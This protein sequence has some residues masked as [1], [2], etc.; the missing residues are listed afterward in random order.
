MITSTQTSAQALANVKEIDENEFVMNATL[1]ICSSLDPDIAL[2]NLLLYLKDYIP[3]AG[4]HL[5]HIDAI[6]NGFRFPAWATINNTKRPKPFVKIPKHLRE[7]VYRFW[8]MKNRFEV[9]NY[10]DI[11]SPQ[12]KEIVELAWPMTSRLT[13]RLDMNGQRIG[14][15]GLFMQG[16]DRFT[17]RHLRLVLKLHD[18]IAMAMSNALKY[19]EIKK[20][21]EDITDDNR[22]LRE[23]LFKI[24]GDEIVGSHS[25]LRQVVRKIEQVARLDTPVLLLGET[26]VGKEVIANTLHKASTRKDGPFIKV[27]CGA[28][29]D[30]LIDSELFGYEKGAF[31]GAVTQKRGRFEQAHNGTIFLDEI[32]ELTTSAQVRLL[33]ILENMEIVRVGG[34]VPIKVNI[35]VISATN[36]DLE[37]MV[38][39][40]AFREDLYFRLNVFPIVIPPL[41]QRKNDIP[42]LINYFIK[43]KRIE[44]NI[45]KNIKPAPDMFETLRDYSWPGNVR[46]LENL[47]ERSLIEAN[48]NPASEYL[49]LIPSGKKNGRTGGGRL[50]VEHKILS[51]DEAVRRHIEAAMAAAC[52]KVEGAGGAAELLDVHPSTLRAKMRKLGIPHG[53]VKNRTGSAFLVNSE[54]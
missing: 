19:Q 20:L 26:G 8:E 9:I 4:I 24:S 47:V 41:R 46:E 23:Q 39:T 31:T 1:R 21:K 27:N 22:Y 30:S 45:G 50:F 33:R 7:R 40:G 43:K 53:R 34:G 6:A 54:Q 35:R 11:K 2:E 49:H 32:G 36:K 15:L 13:M 48:G 14:A 16:K 38:A 44:L 25:G 3:V 28:I 29:P 5:G 12:L 42:L 10:D 37:E 18:P 52:G 51:L 17:D